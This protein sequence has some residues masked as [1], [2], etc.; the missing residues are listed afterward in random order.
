MFR[1]ILFA[2]CLLSPSWAVAQDASAGP[3]GLVEA[4]L[5]ANPSIQARHARE[6][7]L[8]ARARVA[9]AWA[10]PML[11]VEYSN[12]PVNSLDLSLIHI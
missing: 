10:D 9:G 11:M 4:A 5:A 7:A 3:E 12:A 1:C 8:R 6:A 2:G